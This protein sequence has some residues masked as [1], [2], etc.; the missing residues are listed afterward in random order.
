M[1]NLALAFIF[2]GTR[3]PLAVTGWV[4]A[5]WAGAAIVAGVTTILTS[6]FA[7]LVVGRKQGGKRIVRARC[8]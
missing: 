1:Q 6:P 4:A 3:V 5:T 7:G 8:R 2:K